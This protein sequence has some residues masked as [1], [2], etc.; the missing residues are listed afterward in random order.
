MSKLTPLKER[1]FWHWEY[2]S[3]NPEYRIW[4]AELTVLKKQL[5]TSRTSLSLTAAQY[6]ERQT[7]DV[8]LF[9]TYAPTIFE[10]IKRDIDGD[11]NR[12]L[13]PDVL[14]EQKFKRPY[15][16]SSQNIDTTK[17]FYRLLREEEVSFQS[18]KLTDI[19]ALIGAY[20]DW[21]IRLDG[22]LPDHSVT[23]HKMKT[24]IEHG[25]AT[26]ENIPFE[27]LALELFKMATIEE[28]H[29][30]LTTWIKEMA[31]LPEEGFSPVTQCIK[32]AYT[33]Y[34]KSKKS[35]TKS[36]LKASQTELLSKVTEGLKNINTVSKTRLIALWFW[37]NVMDQDYEDLESGFQET[38]D[39]YQSKAKN[40]EIRVFDN[41][42]DNP[43]RAKEYLS[44]TDECIQ[45]MT[46]L[47][48]GS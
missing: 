31:D 15:R 2:Q 1:A 11:H 21:E 8:D 7:K 30:Q 42:L 20:H 16:D 38:Y 40:C 32:N 12:I 13:M 28:N 45:S 46:I 35:E 29:D 43:F 24:V 9:R 23:F 34:A 18:E 6:K 3:R 14:F 47:N 5:E 19:T 37:D 36:Y 26:I 41:F 17:A 10:S 27:L 4:A 25:S 33:D 44:K 22:F 39:F 48:L